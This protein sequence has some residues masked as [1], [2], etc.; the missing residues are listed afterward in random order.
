MDYTRHNFSEPLQFVDLDELCILLNVI[1]FLGKL[2]VFIELHVN[3][4]YTVNMNQYEVLT[5]FG[6]PHNAV[7]TVYSRNIWTLLLKVGKEHI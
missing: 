2:M 1:T 7:H 3:G 5:N 6:A 4:R